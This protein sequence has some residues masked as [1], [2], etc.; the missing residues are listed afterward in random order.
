MSKSKLLLLYLIIPLYAYSAENSLIEKFTEFLP[1]KPLQIIQKNYG[2][3][4]NLESDN[5]SQIYR[6]KI[7]IKNRL[8]NI[9]ISVENNTIIDTFVRLPSY[10][11]HNKFHKLLIKKYGKQGEYFNK[12]KTSIYIW[13][14][15]NL[16]ITYRGSCTITCFPDYLSVT[17][18]TKKSILDELLYF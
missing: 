16:K 17:L 7:Y 14:K 13:N 1:N 11:S 8:I 18:K 12:G 4:K 9:Y 15:D 10:F 2:K 6:Y 5:K 3:V